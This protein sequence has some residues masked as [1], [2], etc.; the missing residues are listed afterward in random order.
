[1][2]K[3]KKTD[4]EYLWQP[5][6]Q[7]G[8]PDML[9]GYPVVR[10]ED[11]PVLATNSLSVAFGDMRATYQI[12]DRAGVRVLRDP[13][14]AKPFVRFYTSRR[15]GGDVVQFETLKFIKFA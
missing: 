8:Q 13:F 15:V 7:K 9:L 14:T 1:M 10:M 12:V 6:I 11:M 5:S 2:R 3:F 4:G